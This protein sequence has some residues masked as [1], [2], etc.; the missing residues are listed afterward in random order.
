MQTV[1]SLGSLHQT[2]F[3]SLCVSD[4]IVGVSSIFYPEK[5]LLVSVQQ[6]QG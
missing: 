6:I 3:T 4:Q 1:L 5:I 2:E